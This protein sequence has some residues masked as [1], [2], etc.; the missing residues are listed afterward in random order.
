MQM[1]PDGQLY[2]VSDFSNSV[3]RF[4]SSTGAFI[5]TV[6][7]TGSGGLNAPAFL[8]FIPD[9]TQAVPEPTS[10]AVFGIVAV[11]FFGLLGLGPQ[12]RGVGGQRRGRAGG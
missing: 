10:L 3:L 12:C 11:S 6:V 5:D 8:T 1:G 4:D 9:Q 7:P 2:V